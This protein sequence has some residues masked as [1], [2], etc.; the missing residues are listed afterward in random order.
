ML[1]STEGRQDRPMFDDESQNQATIPE[2]FHEEDDGQSDEQSDETS[3][4]GGENTTFFKPF[5]EK[6]DKQSD[7]QSDETSSRGGEMESTPPCNLSNVLANPQDY[8]ND[9]AGPQ[10][11]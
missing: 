11:S 10:S 7:K 4:R 3:S 2:P 8:K 6:D 9:T 1:P 5:H